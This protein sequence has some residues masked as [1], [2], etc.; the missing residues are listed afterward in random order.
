MMKKNW[1][2]AIGAGL[3]AA[4]WLGLTGYLWFGPKNPFSDAERRPL[5][6]APELTTDSLLDGKFMTA[7]E[8][9]TLDQFPMRDT[10]RQLKSIFHY[11][12]LRQLDNNDIYVK[13]G[14][15][16]KLEHKIDTHA[17][18]RLVGFLDKVYNL[19]LKGKAENV[20]LSIVPDKSFYL[21]EENGYLS[22]DYD[23]FFAMVKEKTPWASYIDIT[24]S[25][26]IH[27]YYYTDTHWRQE[28]LFDAAQALCQ[29]MGVSA[30]DRGDY[31]KVA[32]ERPFYG[33]YY[34]Q[35]ALPMKPEPLYI[36]KNDI[37]DSCTTSKAVLDF[38]TGQVSYEPL[39]QSVY[40]R[41]KENAKDLYEVYL[42]GSESILRIENPNA[43][44]DKE[45]VVFRDS[46][47]SSMVPLLVNDYRTVTLIDI[48]YISH[49]VLN[50]FVDFTGKDVLF[51]Y[52][53]SVLNNPGTQFMP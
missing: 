53:T 12:V 18:E 41:N 44:T 42:S 33:V 11:Y 20:Y 25:L 5:A 29:G 30:P 13:D 23:R 37:L 8:E 21:A 4:I 19:S 50:R 38:Q 48:R 31:T 27:D 49:S 45:L 7:F 36:L 39:Y 35:A 47:G 22:M 2:R 14:Y 28:K 46:F 15:A 10:M 43:K 32:L 51:L 6:Q 26:D 52:S 34:G 3:V 17:V 9:Y 16:A 1:I 24:G 40:D